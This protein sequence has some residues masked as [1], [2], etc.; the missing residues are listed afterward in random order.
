MP[1]P[2]LRSR[3]NGWTGEAVSL[4]KS[5]KTEFTN[6]RLEVAYTRDGM[7]KWGEMINRARMT[8]EVVEAVGDALLRFSA[9]PSTS[10]MLTGSHN[11]TPDYE[12]PGTAQ[13]EYE[14]HRTVLEALGT[15]PF[16]EQFAYAMNV[17][18]PGKV[19]PTAK[20]EVEAEVISRLR[21]RWK[22]LFLVCST[23]NWSGPLDIIGYQLP[24]ENCVARVGF[25][26]PYAISH[27]WD[28]ALGLD[29]PV[30]YPLTQ[31][32]ADKIVANSPRITE[33][34]RAELQKAVGY[35]KLSMEKTLRTCLAT[36]TKFIIT[37]AGV[38]K[39]AG[40]DGGSAD[41]WDK[42][43]TSV[44]YRLGIPLMKFTLGSVNGTRNY[45]FGRGIGLE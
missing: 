19:D 20:R 16:S 39:Q 31:A 4:G 22:D 44:C 43:I 34:G 8:P 23:R 33:R 1:H 37:E 29:A 18:T 42:D 27:W 32:M 5:A 13:A 21:T 38:F 2:I 14:Y 15:L 26:D 25:Y 6:K 12:A 7:R 45:A 3:E 41:R 30:P 10:V 28:P 36:G 24:A 9:F 35:N 40:S 17:E 11:H